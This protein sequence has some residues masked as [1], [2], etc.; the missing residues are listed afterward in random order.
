[1]HFIVRFEPLPRKAA[2]FREELLRVI[3]RTRTES[4]CLSIR[5]FEAM[6]DP[7]VFAI[8]S[9]W[10]DEAAFEFH[11]TLPHTVRFLAAAEK[12]LPHAVNGLRMR[13]IGAVAHPENRDTFVSSTSQREY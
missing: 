12:L 11:A 7:L 8:H 9:E 13:E 5:A 3:E 6:R 10:V 2:E 4:G 1:M